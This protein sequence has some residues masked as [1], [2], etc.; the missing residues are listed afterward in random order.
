MSRTFE[1][2]MNLSKAEEEKARRE[3]LERMEQE[4]LAV[5]KA[6]DLLHRVRS[7]NFRGKSKEEPALKLRKG[8]KIY[9]T[10]HTPLSVDHNKTHAALEPVLRHAVE[11]EPDSYYESCPKGRHDDIV[12][13]AWYDQHIGADVWVATPLRSGLVV[14]VRELPP[15]WTYLEVTRVISKVDEYKRERSTVFARAHC[16][17]WSELW[18]VFGLPNIPGIETLLSRIETNEAR[19]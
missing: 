13:H 12:M 7:L 15:D 11:P 10:C 6:N 1:K 2:L 19:E 16:G 4:S 14:F 18:Q 17:P 5:R 8:L 9:R 3:R